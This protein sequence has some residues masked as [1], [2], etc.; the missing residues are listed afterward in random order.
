MVILIDNALSIYNFV[1][2][3]VATNTLKSEALKGK[4]I[5]FGET[6]PQDSGNHGNTSESSTPELHAQ[7]EAR[8]IIP[9][10]AIPAGNSKDN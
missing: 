5:T 1:P 6:L 4:E 10:G 3:A 9:P 2:V 7:V 8:V